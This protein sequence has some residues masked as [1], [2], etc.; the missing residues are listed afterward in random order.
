MLLNVYVRIDFFLWHIS[1]NPEYVQG[2]V[3]L[4][5]QIA[6]WWRYKPS[7]VCAVLFSHHRCKEIKMQ[8][9]HL[10]GVSEESPVIVFTGLTLERDFTSISK[11]GGV[12]P[13]FHPR[14][15]KELQYCERSHCL[16]TTQA[17]RQ[18]QRWGM[19]INGRGEIQPWLQEEH[20]KLA[21]QCLVR[22][23]LWMNSI[24]LRYPAWCPGSESTVQS[25]WPLKGH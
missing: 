24:V 9:E 22:S 13:G 12:R 1:L 6:H 20:Q 2:V 21:H 23:V 15:M 17:D 25:V 4:T 8:T 5:F 14:V 10:N 18:S 3:K 19:W 11:A 16:S 7:E